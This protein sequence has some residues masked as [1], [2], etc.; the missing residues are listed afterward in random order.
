MIDVMPMPIM[1]NMMMHVKNT[2]KVLRRTNTV[3]S[4]FKVTSQSMMKTTK[5]VYV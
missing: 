5:T 2:P 4:F 3:K 1:K